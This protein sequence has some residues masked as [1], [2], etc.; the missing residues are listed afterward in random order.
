[1]ASRLGWHVYDHELLERI[2]EDMGVRTTLLESVDERQQGWLL[3]T[4]EAFLSA[5]AESEWTPLVSEG[6]YVRHLVETVLALGAHGECVIV[7]R[8]A[9]FILP[10]ETTLRV[11]LVA[12][13][14]ERARVLAEQFGLP[15][16]EAARRLRAIDR[17]RSDFVRDHFLKDPD[18][19]RNYDLVL[20]TS[21]FSAAEGAELIV[22]ALPRLHP[23]GQRDRSAA[24]LVS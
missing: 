11:R 13:P 10:A 17:E 8:G 20:N 16:P 14:K 22:A 18:D 15:G 2:A 21:R 5:P 19:P 9:A 1:V 24:D 6:A 7:G 3:E 4:V 23:W 12:A